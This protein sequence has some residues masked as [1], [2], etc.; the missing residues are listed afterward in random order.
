MSG[1]TLVLQANNITVL[2]HTGWPTRQKDSS[3]KAGHFHLLESAPL[4]LNVLKLTLIGMF[5]N[6]H[7][8]QKMCQLIQAFYSSQILILNYNR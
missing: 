4:Y 2:Q 8:H 7:A 3:L 6:N 5:R 1:T